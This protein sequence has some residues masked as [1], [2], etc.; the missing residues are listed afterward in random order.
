MRICRAKVHRIQL[1]WTFGT[2]SAFMCL[3]LIHGVALVTVR[4]APLGRLACILAECKMYGLNNGR[5]V[6]L[7]LLGIHTG[8]DGMLPR[9]STA[10]VQYASEFGHVGVDAPRLL[11]WKTLVF[12]VVGDQP[13]CASVKMRRCKSVSPAEPLHVS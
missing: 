8:A 3:P 9:A 1:V 7:G 5:G 6:A 12:A 10:S 11:D 2:L 4:W 13:V